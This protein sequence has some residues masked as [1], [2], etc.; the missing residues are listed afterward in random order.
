MRVEGGGATGGLCVQEGI[1]AI[2]SG[3][4]ELCVCYGF[5]TMSRVP[6]WE[7]NYIIAKASDQRRNCD[8]GGFYSMYYALMADRYMMEFGTNREQLAKISIKNHM[9]AFYNPFAQVWK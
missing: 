2:A 8:L 9:N 4:L 1:R 7:G 3:D 5:E 6:T